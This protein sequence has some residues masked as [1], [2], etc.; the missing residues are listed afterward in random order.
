MKMHDHFFAGVLI[1]LAISLFALT[2]K[3]V[4]KD[5]ASNGEIIAFGM[6]ASFALSMFLA[7]VGIGKASYG[8]FAVHIVPIAAIALHRKLCLAAKSGAKANF[9]PLTGFS[10]T[11]L[12]MILVDIV[13]AEALGIGAE[14]VGGG[15]WFDAL[16]WAPMIFAVLFFITGFLARRYPDQ[17]FAS[18]HSSH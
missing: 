6:L 16:L 13:A 8:F 10:V 5:I 4:R 1:P 2:R 9:N 3:A 18:L 11:F 17:V 14:W 15:A 7:Y 12:T